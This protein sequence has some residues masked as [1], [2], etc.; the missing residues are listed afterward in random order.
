MSC[1]ICLNGYGHRSGVGHVAIVGTDGRI[2]HSYP[3]SDG[4]RIDNITTYMDLFNTGDNFE[5]FRPKT[6]DPESA[7]HYAQNVFYPVIESYVISTDLSDTKNS[8]CSK[9]IWTAYYWA[10]GGV[11]ILGKGY[12]PLVDEI[13]FPS[14][15][16]NA[17]ELESVASFRKN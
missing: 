2:Y 5:V 15:I 13:I 3:N 8:Y 14:E 7:A 17:P 9:F 10:G 12:N 4:K 6:I 16:R 1:T 11:D